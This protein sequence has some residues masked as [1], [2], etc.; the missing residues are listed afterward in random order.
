MTKSETKDRTIALIHKECKKLGVTDS[1]QIA[2]ILATIAWETNHTWKPVKEAY[3]TSEGYRKRHL[4]YYPYYGRGYCQITWETNY[5]KFGKLLGVDFVVHPDLVLYPNYS[6]FIIVYGMK[7]GSFTG[8]RLDDY[9]NKT[10]EDWVGARGIING[11]DKAH[12]IASIAK[13]I[14][15]GE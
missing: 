11:R 9:F 7:H 4:I 13:E 6:A 3:W 12:T 14:Y 5:R 8:K 10:K 15:H 2:Y 1:R